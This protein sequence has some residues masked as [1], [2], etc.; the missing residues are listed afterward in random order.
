MH[1]HRG[2]IYQAA[3][4]FN[5]LLLAGCG[6]IVY[7]DSATTYVAAGRTATKSVA[8]A[9]ASLE[10][11][12]DKL[13]ATKI[14]SDQSCPIAEPRL[15][16]RNAGLTQQLK[17]A[18]TLVPGMQ[19]PP[20]CK[21]LLNCEANPTNNKCR[22]I[23]YSKEEANC[24]STI[25]EN[26]AIYF[27]GL[28]DPEADRFSTV[29]RPLAIAITEAEYGRPKPV[30]AL[31]VK[32][33]LSALTE[34]LD[35]LEKLT[36]KRDSE[37]G[38]DA[39]KLSKKLTD[40]TSALSNLTGKQ[41]S[42]NAKATQTKITGAVTA[43]GKFVGDLQVIADNAQDAQA[44]RKLVAEGRTDVNNLINNVKEVA[45]SDAM[46]GSV[47]N[48]LGLLQARLDLQER[49]STAGDAY[50]R[51]LL[52]MERT[53]YSFSDGEQTQQAVAALFDAMAKSHE[54]LIRLIM[55]PNDKDKQAIANARFQEFK[56]IAEDV[57]TLVQLF[58]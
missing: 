51:D 1:T 12:R 28:K 36:A 10:N 29:I 48:N 9:A 25:E 22:G 46:L 16:L 35:M 13:K 20:D 17:S 57:A 33:N 7:K 56:L 50:S 42:T 58:I 41:L 52:L 3:F 19:Y 30:A 54:A 37:V 21:P 38:E 27:K 39:K 26:L 45:G 47:F 5:T 23:C 8:D 2:L 15:Y 18:L 34:Y 55:N 14:V 32:D 43:M 53:K 6:S 40:T 49:Y 31:L 4:L 44:I 24:I 11:A